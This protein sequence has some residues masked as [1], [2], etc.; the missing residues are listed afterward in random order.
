MGEGVTSRQGW[1][2][3]VVEKFS[4]IGHKIYRMYVRLYRLCYPPL[5]LERV[6]TGDFRSKSKIMLG[7]LIYKRKYCIRDKLN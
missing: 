6:W 1:I 7:F 3:E 5:S 2:N 4:H